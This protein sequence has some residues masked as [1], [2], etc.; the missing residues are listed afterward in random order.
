[1]LLLVVATAS[2]A[3][4]ELN[5]PLS[6]GKIVAAHNQDV[7]EFMMQ[8]NGQMILSGDFWIVERG[9]P[10]EFLLT[11]FKP[12]EDLTIRVETD[13][14]FVNHFNGNF[15]A[16]KIDRFL[17]PQTVRVNAYGDAVIRVGIVI[18]S[19]G[20]GT[21]YQNGPYRA[22]FNLYADPVEQ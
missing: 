16:F 21:A 7:S 6:L 13:N 4:V 15:E 2:S 12:F 19:S 22:A 18:Q 11:G 5:Q 8:P 10:A 1:M 14:G 20:S 17:Y 3:Q 9:Q